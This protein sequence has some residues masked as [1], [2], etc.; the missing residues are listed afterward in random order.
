MD[1]LLEANH[2]DKLWCAENLTYSKNLGDKCA[3]R[4]LAACIPKLLACEFL[5]GGT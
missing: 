2:I 5:N 3:N 4:F 1:A